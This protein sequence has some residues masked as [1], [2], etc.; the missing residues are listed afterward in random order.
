M[1]TQ[2]GMMFSG[3]QPN[4]QWV[5]ASGQPLFVLY[6]KQTRRPHAGISYGDRRDYIRRVGWRGRRRGLGPL[7]W[8]VCMPF[9]PAANFVVTTADDNVESNLASP[10]TVLNP[11]AGIK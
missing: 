1:P 3:A 11:P 9:D 4:P 2:A 10:P 7:G 5:P 8:V 6:S